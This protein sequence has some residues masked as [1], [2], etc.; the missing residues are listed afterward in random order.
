MKRK[1]IALA[2][3]A[4]LMFTQQDTLGWVRSVV[5]EW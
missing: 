3:L 1:Q 2:A 5:G 4:A